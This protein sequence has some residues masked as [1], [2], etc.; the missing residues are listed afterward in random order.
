MTDT[1]EVL[2]PDINAPLV[3]GGEGPFSL[4]Q[5]ALAFAS[6]AVQDEA[7][8]QLLAA[9]MAAVRD[10]WDG[11]AADQ[12]AAQ[13]QPLIAWFEALAVNG[14]ASAA[15]IQSAATSIA[16]AIALSPHP[17]EVTTNRLTWGTLVATNF[18]GVNTPAINVADAQYLEFWFRAAFARASSDIETEVA[19]TT[20]V[21]WEPP[22]TPVNFTMV[23]APTVTAVRNAGFSVPL[24]PANAG[25][26]VAVDAGFDTDLTSGVA[27]DGV[28]VGAGSRPNSS[29]VTAATNHTNTTQ[30][31][32]NP[33]QQDTTTQAGTDQFSQ[34]ASQFAS[35]GGQ[36]G[37]LPAQLGQMLTQPLQQGLQ[38]PSQFSS[39]LQPL[40]NSAS[41]NH[42]AAAAGPLMPVN[43]AS[44]TGNLAAA[45]TRPASGVG[46]LS[47]S[48][49]RLPASSLGTAAESSL[50]EASATRIATAA[51]ASAASGP[52]ATGF[53]GAPHAANQQRRNNPGNKYETHTLGVAGRAC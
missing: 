10:Q 37:Q 18:F 19:T 45:M 16:D 29:W 48:G 17:T 41:L 36:A 43:F 6:A 50:G 25:N 40:M 53:M 3:H 4:E 38:A 13:L 31:Q 9:L 12:Y 15:Q 42:T 5:A 14:H 1:P 27:G 20:L 24:G 11:V 49:L 8:A 30:G 34:M 21:P 35:M 52:G 46:R 23:G 32:N 26:F 47:A 22:P 33:L 28:G 7:N 39:L 2:P 44:G 51:G